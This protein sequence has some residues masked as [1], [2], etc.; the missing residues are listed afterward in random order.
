MEVIHDF[1]K[2]D[3]DMFLYTFSLGLLKRFDGDKESALQNFDKA[4]KRINQISKGV[5]GC[6]F[7]Y[8]AF[9]IIAI[10]AIISA[11]IYFFV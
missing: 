4:E 5:F 9:V 3:D 1:A 2:C 7:G 11:I 8:F 10:I 6:V